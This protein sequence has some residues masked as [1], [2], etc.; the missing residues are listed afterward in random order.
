[1]VV[2]HGGPIGALVCHALGLEPHPD[3]WR[4]FRRDNTGV[5]VLRRRSQDPS[6]WQVARLNDCSHLDL[7]R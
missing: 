2:T 4:R 1:M 5:T 7:E 6:S 3:N